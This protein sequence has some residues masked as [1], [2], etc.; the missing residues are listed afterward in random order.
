MEVALSLSWL[1]LGLACALISVNKLKIKL[2][3]KTGIPGGGSERCSQVLCVTDMALWPPVTMY[4]VQHTYPPSLP[5]TLPAPTGWLQ[6]KEFILLPETCTAASIEGN[7]TQS[8]MSGRGAECEGRGVGHFGLA[9]RSTALGQGLTA[10]GPPVRGEKMS[11]Q[12]TLAFP[13][14]PSP[15]PDSSR[16]YILVG[17]VVVEGAHCCGWPV[18]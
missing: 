11:S 12:E 4:R 10:A 16:G 2:K 15:A 5:S 1:S 9:K 14:E 18:G 17:E 8:G 6:M 3:P 7:S 13:P